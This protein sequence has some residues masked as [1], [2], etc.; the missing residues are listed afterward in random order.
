[1]TIL[2]EDYPRLAFPMRELQLACQSKRRH[3]TDVSL[4]P[5]FLAARH[6]IKSQAVWRECED[7]KP[8]FISASEYHKN[9]IEMKNQGGLVRGDRANR[10]DDSAQQDF[11]D[12]TADKIR[13]YFEL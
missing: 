3:G 2:T 7:E 4:M 5:V 8:D 12:P 1:M 10:S 9:L 13:R 11:L 6:Q